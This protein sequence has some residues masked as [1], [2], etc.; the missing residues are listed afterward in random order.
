MT[1]DSLTTLH[2]KSKHSVVCVRVSRKWE[3]RGGTDDGPI[4]HID[5]VLIDEKGDAIYAEIPSSEIDAISTLIQEGGIYV[6][7]RF[8]VSRAKSLYRPVDVPY[9]IEFTCYT[10]VSPARHVAETFPRYVYRL[11]PF[12]EL[13]KY[14]GENK[15]FL[16]VLGLISEVSETTLL[17]LPNQSSATLNRNIILKDLSNAE[18]K[19]TL[20]GQRA[21]EFT[22]DEVYN[23]EESKPIVMLVVGNLMKS[24]AGE[25]YLSGN[26]ACRWYFNPVIPEAEDF[27]NST[28]NQR[29][30]IKRS[31][32]PT[33][34]AALPQPSLQLEDKHLLDLQEMDPYDFPQGGCRCTVTI[35]RLN[36]NRPWWFPSCNRCSRACAP[37]GDSYK[38]N[39]CSCTGYRF[40]YKLSFIGNDGTAE[41]EMIAFR[42]VARRIVGKPVQQVLRFARSANDTPPDIAAI[43]SLK[44]TF[45]ITLTDQSYYSPHRTYQIISIIT[46]YGRQQTL[47][48]TTFSQPKEPTTSQIANPIL[49]SHISTTNPGAIVPDATLPSGLKSD[50]SASQPETQ[51]AATRNVQTHSTP[52]PTLEYDESPLKKLEYPDATDLSKHTSA[53][54]RLFEDIIDPGKE[55]TDAQKKSKQ[56]ALTGTSNPLLHT[57]GQRRTK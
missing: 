26:T 35:T 27:Y 37:S 28:H 50:T 51:K 40:K 12:A 42:E 9:M 54:K 13:P 11:T 55:D 33:H 24:F 20:W 22:I 44:F 21:A 15:H 3:Y 57:V 49:H 1:F 47:P 5:L 31:T 43:V 10:K 46:S 56:E 52:P 36:S 8:R 18:V 16:D 38:C 2:P 30:T 23:E 19:L 29:L 34:Q 17:Q 14:A 45:A 53:Q 41:A 4:L 6:I 25:E 7:S 32:P 39:T 48:H